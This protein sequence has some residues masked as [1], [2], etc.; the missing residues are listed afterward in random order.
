MSTQ[1]KRTRL[2]MGNWKM[3]GS[4]ASNQ[5]LLTELLKGLQQ[6]PT[7]HQVAVCVPYVYLAQVQSLLADSPIV[8]GAQDVSAHDG[9]AY[10]GEVSAAMLKEFGCRFVLVGH[11]ERRQY[12]SESNTL[13][14]AKVQQVVAHGMR[15]VLCVGETQAQYDAHQ[16]QEVLAQQLAPVLALGAQQLSGLVVAYEPVW[17]IG[18]GQSASPEYAQ[19]VHEFIRQQLQRVGCESVPIVYG[20]SVNAD[21]AAKLF[22]QPNI[23]GALVGG[24]SLQADSFLRIVA[25]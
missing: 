20:G 3:N 21:N 4:L 14:A 23:Q 15:P 11:S 5:T 22:A 1:N 2:L 19:R 16:T 6:Q 17:A 12:F 8:W 13:I 7:E 10:T 9:G 24:A 25:A 18:S